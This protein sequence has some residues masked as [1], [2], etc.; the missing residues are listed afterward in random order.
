LQWGERYEQVPSRF[1]EEI[2]P[3]V[4]QR[5]STRRRTH[6]ASHRG[7]GQKKQRTRRQ[8]GSEYSQ[9]TEESYSQIEQCIETGSRVVHATFGRGKIMSIQG[10][11]DMARAVVLFESV[12]RKTLILKYAGLKPA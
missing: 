11:G 6:A 10:N 1:I 7:N 3:T 2:D 4:V 9:L 8:A 12:G 5:E